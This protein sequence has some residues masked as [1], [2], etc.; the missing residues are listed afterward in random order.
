MSFIFSNLVTVIFYITNE[1]ATNL[2]V[3]LYLQSFS[4]ALLPLPYSSHKV[5]P[6]TDATI[7]QSLGPVKE[8]KWST[9]A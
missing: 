6:S 9:G 5:Q 4:L 1:L 7:T 2:Y 8:K 3:C